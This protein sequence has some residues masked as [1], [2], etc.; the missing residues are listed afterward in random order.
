MTHTDPAT[1]IENGPR[2]N[3]K[4]KKLPKF[5]LSNIQSFGSSE[6]TDKTTE[7][8]AVLDLNSIDIATLTETWLTE[9][10]KDEI[11]LNNYV[12]FHSVRK[13]TLRSSGGVSILIRENIP[14]NLIDIKVPEHIEAL[15]VSVRPNWLPRAISNIVVC[16]VYYPGHNSEYAPDQND[17]ILH[18]TETMHYLNSKYANPLFV[19]MGDFNDLKTNEIRNACSLKQVVKVPTRKN[20]T[21][22]LILTNKSNNFYKDPITLP[23]IST[24]DHLCVLYE[25]IVYTNIKNEKNK[26]FIRKFHKSAMIAFG[27][28]L[29]SFDWQILLNITDVNLKV[30]YFFTIMWTSIDKYF[31]LIKVTAVKNDKEWITPKIKSLI[32]DRQKAHMCGNFLKRNQLADMVRL[33]VKKAKQKYN[34]AKAKT[35]SNANS[36]EWF[37]HITNIINNGKRNNI[38]L[39]NIPELTQKPLDEIVSIVNNHF[40]TICKT[41]PPI[42]DSQIINNPNEPDLTL[43][44]EFYTYKLLNKFAKKS[45][46]PRDFPKQILQEFAIFLALPFSDITN[47]AIRTGIFPDAFKISEIVPIPKEKPPRSLK[48]LRPI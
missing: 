48:D 25:P 47:C 35:F 3:T 21:L 32:A 43:I 9:N 15:W 11:K 23:S 44:S 38:V 42:N 13:N 46:G 12:N 8:E 24:S 6:N 29:I 34:K 27:A 39:N 41:Y 2:I 31:P 10:N 18:L 45:T 33:E 30:A 26:I 14:A 22:D 17:I 1:N 5:L 40:A 16:G 19:I 20:A 28:W 36:K 37:Q 7:V 4:N